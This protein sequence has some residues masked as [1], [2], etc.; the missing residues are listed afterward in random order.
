ML[1]DLLP[2]LRR[3]GT[4]LMLVALLA[5]VVGNVIV[6]ATASAPAERFAHAGPANLHMH[7]DGS[8][9]SHL[10]ATSVATDEGDWPD[11]PPLDDPGDH[12]HQKASCCNL[13]QPV[14]LLGGDVGITGPVPGSASLA[15]P[16][17][18]QPFGIDPNDL[19]RPPRTLSD[20]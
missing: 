18:F 8:V 20:A 16:P 10:A 4:S 1:R 6:P 2:L 17:Q 11:F 7:G 3:I 19:R 9:H 15:L 12:E 13:L 14:A 5:F